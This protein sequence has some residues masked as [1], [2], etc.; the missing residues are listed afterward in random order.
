MLFAAAEPAQRYRVLE[1]FYRL[2]RSLIERFYAGRMTAGDKVR[3]LIGKPP[4]P[5]GKA[6]GVL[7]GL[8]NKPQPLSLAG[9]RA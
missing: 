2:D 9:T 7:T 1:R 4:V 8:G 5:V 6:I 3:I